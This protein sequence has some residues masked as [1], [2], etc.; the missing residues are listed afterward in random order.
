[1]D[2]SAGGIRFQVEVVTSKAQMEPD[3]ERGDMC[4]PPRP[5]KR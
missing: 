2:A 1:M 3:S 5:L 4:G